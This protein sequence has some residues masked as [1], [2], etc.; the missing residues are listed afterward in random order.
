MGSV[1][2]LP[3]LTS[4]DLDYGSLMYSKA[5]ANHISILFMEHVSVKSLLSWGLRKS[6]NIV[7][8]MARIEILGKMLPIDL[9]SY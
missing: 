4:N 8:H 7:A 6:N 1:S 2:N 3:M 5:L 9:N